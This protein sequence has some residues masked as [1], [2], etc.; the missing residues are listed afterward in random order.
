MMPVSIVGVRS[1]EHPQ[2]SQVGIFAPNIIIIK[3]EE[4]LTVR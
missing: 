4:A 1:T 2:A 3:N